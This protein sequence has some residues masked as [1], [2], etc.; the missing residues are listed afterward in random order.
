MVQRAARPLITRICVIGAQ[1]LNCSHKFE[2]FRLLDSYTYYLSWKQINGAEN[3][4]LEWAI[5]KLIDHLWEWNCIYCRQL[6]AF[7]L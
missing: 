6:H 2:S 3:G 1:G 5:N 7:N 4:L